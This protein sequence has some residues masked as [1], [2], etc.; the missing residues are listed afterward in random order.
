MS[1]GTVIL[2]LAALSLST[3][4]DRDEPSPRWLFLCVLSYDNDLEVHAATVLERL[5]EGVRGTDHAVTVLADFRG[6]GGLRRYE[7]DRTGT[8]YATLS[9]DDS[10]S[11][12]V[13]SEYLS[14]ATRKYPDRRTAV[15]FLD[16]G[17]GLDDMCQ[18][19]SPPG[20]PGG[21]WLS[22]RKVGPM[23]REFSAGLPG[24]VELLFLQQC[25]RGSVECLYNFRG[26]ARAVLASQT[27]VGAPNTYYVPVLQWLSANPRAN[28]FAL[29]ERI[30]REDDDF[31]SYACVD[32]EIL[33]E[34]PLRLDEVLAALDG[35]SAPLTAPPQTSLCYFG[36]FR[37]DE[38]FSDL[39][40]WFEALYEANGRRPDSDP[41]LVAFKNWLADR[42]VVGH[43]RHGRT[44]HLTRN[45]H[46]LALLVPR[47]AE[48]RARYADYPLYRDSD[49]DDFWARLTW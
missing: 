11:E 12:E 48:V 44:A 42:L 16:H 13:L 2:I 22:A 45:W 8:R 37:T 38:E 46:G 21:R 5:G 24:G 43:R 7:I 39:V 27:R 36:W 40:D 31:S 10:A 15:V 3:C 19:L 17:G 1:R 41:A 35:A 20:G 30:M 23:L 6:P 26:V 18:D 4:A 14:W 34:L 29:A 49:L 47:S 25:G 33:G 32:G 9:T 28:G